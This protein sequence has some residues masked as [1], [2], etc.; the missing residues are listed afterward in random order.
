MSAIENESLFALPIDEQL[1]LSDLVIV[2]TPNNVYF[3]GGKEGGKRRC[4]EAHAHAGTSVME[5]IPLKE[6]PSADTNAKQVVIPR[7]SLTLFRALC[8]SSFARTLKDG[9]TANDFARRFKDR[10]AKLLNTAPEET[11]KE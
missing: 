9:G 3:A 8:E 4:F 10:V 2:L 6:L 5:Y 1:A 11:I 7:I